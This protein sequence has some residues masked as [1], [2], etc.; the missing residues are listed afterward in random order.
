MQFRHPI[1]RGFVATILAFAFI[2]PVLSSVHAQEGTEGTPTESSGTL[3]VTAALCSEG[4]EPETVL[5]ALDA[6]I[7]AGAS[8][9]PADIAISIDGGEA[10]GVSGSGA[11]SLPEGAHSVTDVET[12]Q[13]LAVDIYADTQTM[14]E[15]V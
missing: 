11:F 13:S 4:G 8:C 7:A 15:R 9:T 5:I 6:G 3:L 10:M 12:G 2:F 14:I 1:V